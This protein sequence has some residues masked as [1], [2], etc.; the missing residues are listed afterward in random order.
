MTCFKYAETVTSVLI[1][2]VIGVSLIQL[3]LLSFGLIVHD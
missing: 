1:L 2:G 3:S